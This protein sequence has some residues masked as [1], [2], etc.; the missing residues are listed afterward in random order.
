MF[1]IL[2]KLCNL[3]GTSGDENTV[4]DFII[5]EIK[6]YCQYKTDNLGN[7][8]AFK[9]GKNKS[10]KRLMVDAHMDE[11]GL[12][13][14]SVTPE[15]FLKFKTVGG[16]DTAALMFRGVKINGKMGGV[17]SGKPVH[18]ISGEER[19][20]PPQKDSLYIDIG[21]DSK[22]TALKHIAL[23]DRAVLCGDYQE[24]GDNIISK[25]LDDR[26]G[27]AVLIKL[28]KEYDAYGFYAVFS[29]QEEVGCRGAKVAAF[30]VKP[31]SAIALEGTTAAD[32]SG[33]G[34]E[35][36]V[37]KLNGGPAVS[38]MDGSTVYDK[39]YYNYALNSP[40]TCQPK[41]AVT[42]GNNSGAIH[43]SREGVRTIA[44]SLPC[45][46]IHSASSV[47]CKNDCDSLYKLA[48]FMIEGICGDKLS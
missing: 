29:V 42:G 13:I 11:A 31:D 8:I 18:L 6:D 37:C 25:A 20:K 34:E 2:E 4:R 28:I 5:N 45:R 14:T 40:I 9:K 19:K 30:A 48:C 23:G 24:S 3:D 32:I 33:V 15:G 44:L 12:I 17:I 39:D 36:T 16:I 22:E 1:D 35:N 38:F 21:A 26:V 41:S 7:I 46:Y 43:L 47:A 27:C 10:L